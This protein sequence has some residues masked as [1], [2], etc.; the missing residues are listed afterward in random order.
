MQFL[1]ENPLQRHWGGADAWLLAAI[2]YTIPLYS[3]GI[4]MIDYIFN[5]LVVSS[6]Y[7]ILYVLVLGVINKG[8]LS[9]FIGDIKNNWK[10]VVFALVVPW[11]LLVVFYLMTYR[12]ISF[13]LTELLLL[14]TLLVL[15]WRYAKVIDTKVFRKQIPANKLKVGDVMDDMIWKGMTEEDI[16]KVKKSRRNVII[17]EGVRL[18]PAFPIALVLTILYGNLMFYII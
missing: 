2:A 3:N 10:A 9:Y 16:A 13:P 7:M 17:K 5:F 14:T 15:F 6:G 4:F 18:I 8:V 12:V 11:S 1:T